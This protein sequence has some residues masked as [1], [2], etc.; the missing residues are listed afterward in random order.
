MTQAPEPWIDRILARVTRG[1]SARPWTVVWAALAVLAGCV[2]Y[3]S[4]L[5][6]RGDFLELLPS[7]SVGAR[8]FRAS[9]AR[10]GGGNAT[11]LVMVRSPDRQ[12]NRR[13]VDALEPRL[14]TLPRHL[15][16]TVEKGPEEAR[17]FFLA[18]RWL[19]AEVGDL[20]ELEC[21]V[22]R[23]R[24]RAQPG[25]VDLDDEPCAAQRSDR[26][27]GAA[28]PEPPATAPANPSAAASPF[29]RFRAQVNAR[30]RD[31]DRFPDGYFHDPEGTLWAI[32]VR[33]PG[34]GTGDRSGDDLLARVRAHVEAVG[35]RGY[36]PSLE[37]GYAGDIPNAIEERKALENDVLVVTLV[38]LVLILGSITVFFRS[39]AAIF[40]VGFA[41][42]LG[43]AMAFALAMGAFGYLNASTAFLGSIIAGNGINYGI[44]YLARYRECRVAGASVHDALLDAVKTCRVGTSLASLAAAGAYG[45][46]MLT[47]F[48]GFSQ[49]GLIGAAGMLACWA[50]TMVVMPA[51]VCAW[52][53]LRGRLQEPPKPA[54]AARWAP[55]AGAVGWLSSRFP[56]AVLILGVALSVAAVWRLPGY[57]R[58]PWEYNF[59]K[60]GS[61]GSHR[62]GA[63]Q[64]S[65][66]AD[67]L[68]ASH[69]A[70]TLLLANDLQEVLPLAEALR[71]RDRTLTGGRYV[72][73]VE[74]LW[75]RLGGPP[76]VV[77]RKLELLASLRRELDLLLPSLTG[78][79]LRTA[80]E[81]RPPEA[82]GVLRPEALPSL[83]REQFTERDGRVGTPFFVYFRPDVWMSDGRTLLKVA[84]LTQDLPLPDGRRVPTVSRAAVFAEMITCMGRDGP[85]A[86]AAAFGAVVLL[87]L[88]AT[89]RLGPAAAVLG[90]LLCGVAWTVG[91]A[92]WLGVRL[93]FLNFVALPL[94]FGIGVEY[95]V[96]LQDRIRHTRGAVAEAVRSVGGAVFLCSFTT[97]VGYGAL[98]TSDNQALQSFGS[99]AIA[100]ELSCIVT[101]L[102]LLPAA[103]SLAA[104]RAP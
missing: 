85:R 2:G 34:T 41:M 81:W 35:P 59:S 14:R 68:F 67:R 37:V 29:E 77:A 102:F 101:A 15:V 83:V 62:S 27:I 42:T 79:D 76:S 98:L 92:A 28:A 70:P 55:V 12:A 18:N 78:E 57:L 94:T 45:S 33:S 13:F 40:Q 91:G 4:R 16:R 22:S 36:H 48:R 56:K 74:T 49:F 9:L 7:E 19:F 86:T 20:E 99:Y 96:N 32:V 54:G 60:L 66:Q 17:R 88:L 93:N 87:V 100:G 8:S 24:R 53:G 69:G 3:A 47:S 51:S 38:A 82:L 10:M 80:R 73:R 31:V 75:D 30:V 25:F 97:I 52:E 43:V 84:R 44:I 50:A 1:A 61:R 104:R 63:G 23:A 58:D 103:L 39:G 6:L 46:L 89:R 65:T 11:L 90:S 21:E 95:A 64:W 26:G 72:E 71:Q 5:E